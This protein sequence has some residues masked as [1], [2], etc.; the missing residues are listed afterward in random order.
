MNWQIARCCYLALQVG[1]FILVSV[2]AS[3]SIACAATITIE[4]RG[5]QQPALVF[6]DGRLEPRDD[7]Q[8]RIKASPISKA[9]V[10]F[11]SDGG[12]VRA[13]IQIGEF[14]RLKGFTT[15]VAE[16]S[17]CAS[18]CALAW[19]GGTT[20]LMSVQSRI[21]FHAAYNQA[22]KE[23]GPGNALIGAYLS[24]IGLPD[25]AVLYITQAP[26]ESMTWLSAADAVKHGIDVELRDNPRVA[27]HVPAAPP[28][29]APSGGDGMPPCM[30]EFA[31]LREDVEKKGIAAKAAG[32]RKATR[33]EMCKHITDYSSAE[34]KWVKFSESNISTCG[35]PVQV[36]Q[37]LKQVHGHTEK[38]KEK[39][40][41]RGPL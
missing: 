36:V 19:L 31:K 18:A 2:L 28:I 20:R 34:L 39:I 10:S 32:I 35:I 41:A 29:S 11:R 33:E 1:P 40:C 17:L 4:S 14:I 26:P 8:F 24:R 12:D 27:T 37:Q 13:S 6:V 9:L 5:D 30:T 3:V 22:G 7:H 15:V 23:T 25:S 21:G 38:T 16:N